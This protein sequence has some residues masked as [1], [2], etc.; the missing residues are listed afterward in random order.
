MS[1]FDRIASAV[2]TTATM[3]YHATGASQVVDGAAQV[4]RNSGEGGTWTGMARGVAR[5]AVG[6]AAL[7]TLPTA[8][9]RTMAVM[10][11]G[12]LLETTGREELG[13]AIKRKGKQE[14]RPDLVDKGRW[15]QYGH[16]SPDELFQQHPAAFLRTYAVQS[17]VQEPDQPGGAPNTAMPFQF[18]TVTSRTSAFP[19]L[20]RIT[21]ASGRTRRP[22]AHLSLIHSADAEN[23]RE[24]NRSRQVGHD[25]TAA[26]LP[27]VQSTSDRMDAG[28]QPHGTPND[29]RVTGFSQGRLP[30]NTL[31]QR[32]E[33]TIVTTQLSGCSVS[34]QDG[35]FMHIRPDT[36]APG[37]QQTLSVNG[38][39]FGRNDY[40]GGQQAFVMIRHKPDGSAR[41]HYQVHD[42]RA[43]TIRSGRRN[44]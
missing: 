17:K 32:A 43:G 35:A 34:R 39:T 5:M 9:L 14:N 1:Y 16:L 24:V 18:R 31:N 40:P 44:L 36:D 20:D 8:P 30:A 29:T 21:D 7:Y 13:R 10:G 27:M 11:A 3:A 41:L 6:G 42:D 15:L 22:L 38:P 23:H 19:Q 33:S 28:G 4:Y 12:K 2:K 37:L 25:F 26:F